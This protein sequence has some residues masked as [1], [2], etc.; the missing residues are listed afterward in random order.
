[1]LSSRRKPHGFENSCASNRPDGAI[2]VNPYS[3]FS[4]PA[5]DR[6]LVWLSTTDLRLWFYQGEA[7]DPFVRFLH[8]AAA[9]I[10]FG[11]ILLVDLRLMGWRRTFGVRDLTDLALPWAIGGG[12]VAIVTGLALLLF[13][14]IAVGVHT[15]FLPKMF[16]IAVGG[17][18]AIGFHRWVRI[19]GVDGAQ[20]RAAFFA[21]GTSILIWA[22]VFLCAA[23]NATERISSSA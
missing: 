9:S 3:D 11:A 1:M 13:D 23:L 17:L 4:V 20:A 7:Y 6:F 10:L 18:N 5:F 22:G 12:I 19:A 8:V 16:L 2:D 14:P 21:G 15:F